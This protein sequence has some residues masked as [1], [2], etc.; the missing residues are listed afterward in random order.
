MP[1]GE[2][3]AVFSLAE[4]S[5]STDGRYTYIRLKYDGSG[6]QD[7]VERLGCQPPGRVPVTIL[8]DNKRL[9]RAT[10][11][12]AERQY[13]VDTVI[14]DTGRTVTVPG[15]IRIGRYPGGACGAS[16]GMETEIPVTRLSR[17]TQPGADNLL[18]YIVIAGLA[19]A[20]LALLAA[21]IL[22]QN[23]EKPHPYL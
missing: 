22:S 2:P 3:P 16:I 17:P 12:L 11:V 4:Y 21:A 20:P 19:I 8:M 13:V 10:A 9:Y 18:G 23:T 7:S 14:N 5:A 15:V 6:Y 1:N